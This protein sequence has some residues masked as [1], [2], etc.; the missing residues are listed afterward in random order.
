MS[1]FSLEAAE[2]P[3]PARHD[4][5]HVMAFVND[6]ATLRELQDG[7]IDIVP[8]GMELRRGGIRAAIAAMQKATTPRVLV[9]D[10]AGD[11]D[12]IAALRKLGEVV[13]PDVCVLAVGDVDDIG[14][15]RQVTRGLGV[16][17]YLAKP[18]TRDLIGRHF[19][20]LVAGQSPDAAV[21][22]GGRMVTITGTHGGVGASVIAANL[23]W[24]LG[25]QRR[26]HTVLLDADL[27]RGVASLLLNTPAG[28]GL[29]TALEEPDRLDSLLAERAAQPAADR[30]HVLSCLEDLSEIPAYAEGAA[31]TLLEALRARYNFIVADTPFL[32]VQF[33]RDL[34]DLGHQRVLV[35]L[36][37]LACI[38]DTLRMLQM[39]PGSLQT[40]RPTV[41]LN[42]LGM[43]GGLARKQVEDALGMKADVVIPDLPKQVETA[44]T[45]G[46][47]LAATRGPFN[48]AIVELARQVAASDPLD[49]VGRAEAPPPRRRWRLPFFR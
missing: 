29:R 49:A 14:F 26:R 1:P 17:E 3:A 10:I 22:L 38:R 33:N 30:L 47:P 25:V 9:V 28:R 16:M 46:E 41:V 32:P 40:R 8:E 11:D 4:R 20:P 23:A 37:T 39:M 35:M 18:L 45:V 5:Q 48:A 2:A 19:G 34:L 42:R 24:N 36:P 43:P 6:N 15:Y 31:T 44:T 12:P 13:E 27:H 21:V 7:L